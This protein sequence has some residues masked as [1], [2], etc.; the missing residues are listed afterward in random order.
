MLLRDF[1]TKE[2][3]LRASSLTSLKAC[4]GSLV[5][6]IGAEDH[7]GKA[8]DTG[9]AV[10]Q[11]IELFHRGLSVQDSV[12][13]TEEM[14]EDGGVIGGTDRHSYPLADIPLAQKWME[15][16]AADPR[17]PVDSVIEESLEVEVELDLDPFPTDPTGKKIHIVGHIDQIRADPEDGIWEVW[18]V[19]SGSRHN[20]DEMVLEYSWQQAA[21]TLGAMKHFKRPMRWGGI[22]YVRGY[23]KQ[24]LVPN[25]K[26]VYGS[27][28]PRRKRVKPKPGME[29]VF[30]RAPFSHDDLVAM[31][32][33]VRARVAAIRAGDPALQIGDHC[34]WCPATSFSNCHT[35]V[36]NYEV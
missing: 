17:N 28:E 11:M 27:K 5:M 33:Q 6:A 7:G 36:K 31:M 14:M 13:K 9:T 15:R 22:V 26:W 30:F 10:G 18:D 8:A 16:Y 21:Y 32:Y 12:K 29:N 20:G 2:H 34:R 24:I 35:L 19:K 4:P 25:P 1:G 23:E 3:P